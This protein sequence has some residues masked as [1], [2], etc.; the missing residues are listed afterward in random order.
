MRTES[1]A[2]HAGPQLVALT[3]LA[4]APQDPLADQPAASVDS[5]AGAA[6]RHRTLFWR[7]WRGWLIILALV[8]AFTFILI[9]TQTSTSSTALAPDNPAAGG[10]RALA[11][12]LDH[13][14]V[15][16]VYV[17]TA[18]E[19][20]QAA[21][22]AH[23]DATI[24]VAGD[25]GMSTAQA[26]Q[27]QGAGKALVLFAPQTDLLRTSMAGASYVVRQSPQTP[28][29]ANCSD[30]DATAAAAILSPGTGLTTSSESA[31][32]CFGYDDGAAMIRDGAVTVLDST[33]LITNAK[34]ASDGNAALSLRL[35]GGYPTV[36]WL[37]PDR[38]AMQEVTAAQHDS[39]RDWVAPTAW[40]L[41]LSLG[42]AMWWR[43]RRF[44][45]LVV[46]PMP[47]VVRSSEV[48]LGRARLYRRSRK[49]DHAAALLRAGA[50]TRMANR[51]GLD[52]HA[53]PPAVVEAIGVASGQ[54]ERYI[55]DLLYGPAPTD[56][57]GLAHLT[58]E[59]DRLSREVRRP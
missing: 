7:R 41:I 59:L 36:V 24:V 15:H 12:I 16:V 54:P 58:T 23:G 5:A 37:V 55:H 47:V 35:V 28:V 51:I 10:A 29:A 34:L 31:T 43:G 25:F 48:T 14:G 44:G 18:S 32:Q 49:Y 57:A 30:P 46:E 4:N 53:S 50:A 2:A 19:A 20:A 52:H 17:R 8:A 39:S 33:E 13:Q 1:P 6:P 45:P 56:A 38:I 22:D 26:K 9:A 21:Q 42:F 3:P 40:V 27:L 11:Q